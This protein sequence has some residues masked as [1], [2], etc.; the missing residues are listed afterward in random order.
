MNKREIDVYTVIKPEVEKLRKVGIGTASL[1]CRLLLAQILRK[2][3]PLYTHQ[4][5]FISEMQIKKFQTLVC[6]RMKGK[7]VSRILNKKNFWKREFK[8]NEETL[9]PRPDSE[10]IIESVL[11]YFSNK[12]EFLKIL[13]LGS[14]S[15]CLGLSLGDEYKASS[16]TFADKS[17]KSLEI[18]RMNAL[19]L[20]ING[21]IE[22]INMDWLSYDWDKKLL[23]L[24]KKVKYDVIVINPPYIPSDDIK[25]LKTE[26]KDYDPALALDGGKDGLSA[27]RNI[28]PKLKNLIKFNGKI[29]IEIGKGQEQSVSEIGLAHGL[30]PLEY[31]KDLSNISRVI[32]FTIK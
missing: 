12:S 20:G 30:F 18:V 22:F 19:K 27:Y 10:I 13:D 5:I 1:D 15:G 32:I 17:K 23:N 6:E 8:L 4:S 3:D 7:P 29:F 14:G 24:K 11:K 2:D 26:V 9:D 21:K 31:K 25:L 16:V 28:I